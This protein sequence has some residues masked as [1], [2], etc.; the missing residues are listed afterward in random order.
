[1]DESLETPELWLVPIIDPAPRHHAFKMDKI[2]SPLLSASELDEAIVKITNALD[3]LKVR[4]GI[5]GSTAVNLY[6]RHYGFPHHATSNI[7]IIVQPTEKVSAMEISARFAEK[8]FEADFVCWMIKGVR[9]PKVVVVRRE[10]YREQ[11]MVVSFKLLDHYAYPERRMHYDFDLGRLGN[12]R[13][14]W[15][16]CGKR[17]RLLNAP[18]LLRQKILAWGARED[19]EERRMDVVDIKTLCDIVEVQKKRV[20]FRDEEEVQVLEKFV[21]NVSEDPLAFRNA[22]D[23]PQVLGPWREIRWIKVLL[24]MLAVFL[25]GLWLDYAYSTNDW[26]AEKDQLRW[27]EWSLKEIREDE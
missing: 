3:T 23:C 25:F 6:A 16:V 20:K 19:A 26:D 7:S 27:M 9:V 14:L 10:G 12:Q 15:G 11:R 8:R 2:P 17:V 13:I 22:I 21:M 5:V 18:W 4:Y 24:I 1:M